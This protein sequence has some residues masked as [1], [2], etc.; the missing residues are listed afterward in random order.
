MRFCVCEVAGRLSYIAEM[1]F[2]CYSLQTNRK[3]VQLTSR[4]KCNFGFDGHLS[5]FSLPGKGQKLG[6]ID[7]NWPAG[8]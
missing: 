5:A 1:V 8:I 7:N 3:K 2:L 6:E 4:G